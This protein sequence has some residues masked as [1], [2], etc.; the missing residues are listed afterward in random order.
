M[1]ELTTAF[2]VLH[3]LFLCISGAIQLIIVMTPLGD[4]FLVSEAQL[5]SSVWVE[6]VPNLLALCLLL[7]ALWYFTRLARRLPEKK[8]DKAEEQHG[9]QDLRQHDN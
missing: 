7:M 1:R 9:V 6:V 5:I 2:S 3:I 8:V 4:A